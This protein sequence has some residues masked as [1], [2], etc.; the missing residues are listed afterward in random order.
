MRCL[1]IFFVVALAAAGP[2]D[3]QAALGKQPE[4][5]DADAYTR[6]ELL[7]PE[8]GRFRIIYDVS[9]TT[10][11]ATLYFNAIR[12][13][14]LASDE[15]V[16]DRMSGKP[17]EFAIVRGAVAR[18]GGVAGA[19]TTGEYIRVRLARPVPREGE[20][21]LR[22]DKTY[23]DTASYFVREGLLIF[24]RQLGIKRNAIVLPAGYELAGCNYPSQVFTEPDG[25]IAVSYINPGPAEVP[26]IL[27]A[28][29]IP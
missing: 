9:A 12:K 2:A 15:A 11:G 17:L 1:V 20:V 22:I 10:P 25:R 3:A 21:R 7:A 27:K 13:G 28:R 18:A 16:F 24:S 14:S 23:R 6:Y 29:R 8:S 19:D 26:L 5:T 4:Q